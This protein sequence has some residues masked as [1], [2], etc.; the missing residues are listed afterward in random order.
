MFHLGTH[1]VEED[2]GIIRV[3]GAA[4]PRLTASQ[5]GEQP[6]AGGEVKEAV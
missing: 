1:R 5:R 6:D 3:K 2:G 4:Q